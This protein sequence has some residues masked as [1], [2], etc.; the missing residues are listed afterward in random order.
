MLQQCCPE[1]SKTA[2]CVTQ[3][4]DQLHA[5][6]TACILATCDD[7]DEVQTEYAAVSGVSADEDKDDHMDIDYLTKRMRSDVNALNSGAPKSKIAP[8][9]AI[10]SDTSYMEENDDE[11]MS[12]MTRGSGLASGVSEVLDLDRTRSNADPMTILDDLAR[13]Y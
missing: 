4:V 5:A 6:V 3:Q 13:A 12:E 10:E 8:V 11:D 1:P 7:E 9:K 2:N